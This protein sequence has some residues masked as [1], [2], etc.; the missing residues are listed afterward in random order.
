MV[1]KRCLSVIG[2]CALLASATS[3]SA[4]D[5]PLPAPT[6]GAGMRASFAHTDPERATPSDRVP[7][8]QRAPVRQRR[9]AQERQV[10]VQH[11]VQ[12]R[13]NDVGVLDAGGA[14]RRSRRSSTSGSGR[15]LPPS[16]RANLYGPYYAQPLGG[17]HRRRPGR[18]SV[19]L[20]G[21]RQR[22]RCTGASSARSRSRAASFDGADGDRRRHAC[23]RAGRVQVDFWDPEA[24]YYLNGTYYG[25]KNLLA[26]GVAG[27]VQGERQVGLQR[28]LPARAKARR[29]R[30]LHGRSRVGQVR[31]SSAATT[32]DYGDERRRLRARRLPVPEAGRHRA[33]SRCSASTRRRNFSEGVDGA[34]LD[35]DQKTTE[36]NFN[37]VIKQFNARVMLFYKDTRFNA[38]QTDFKQFG[39]GLQIQM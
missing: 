26:I 36:I 12:R 11:R 6:I 25:D 38:V 35:Y 39:V 20:P 13:D 14:V 22:R 4:Q 29:R 23:S 27:Q 17:L 24:G 21:P 9:G 33:R 18:L 15:F 37:Y 19:H 32:R 7:A 3:A 2:S 30:R 34:D 28:R 31:P 10:H 16:D 5:A 8:R 1:L